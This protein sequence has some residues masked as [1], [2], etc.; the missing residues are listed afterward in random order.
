MYRDLL[1][2]GYCKPLGK[3]VIGLPYETNGEIDALR[4]KTDCGNFYAYTTYKIELN[5]LSAFTG[6]YDVHHNKIWENDVLNVHQFLFDGNEYEKEIIVSIEYE[7]HWK[8]FSNA[9]L[10]PCLYASRGFVYCFAC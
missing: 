2:K 8:F 10:F 7:K 3:W 5:T 1:F 9:F 4:V 6:L